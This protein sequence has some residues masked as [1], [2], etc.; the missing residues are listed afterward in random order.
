EKGVAVALWAP[1]TALLLGVALFVP[2]LTGGRAIGGA[3]AVAMDLL[4]M[5]IAL[6][7]F[8]AVMAGWRRFGHELPW[9]S[10]P[11]GDILGPIEGIFVRTPRPALLLE[12]VADRGLIT[13]AA[14][15]WYRLYSE[16]DRS[17]RLLRM[18]L[19]LTRWAAGV[20]LLLLL[21]AMVA[22]L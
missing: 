12:K 15:K 21:T 9:P 14:G 11:P 20:A 8:A 17:D 13:G 3:A 19:A 4:P 5:T 6:L 2:F 18:E 10:I 7:L 16:S 22:M 1:W